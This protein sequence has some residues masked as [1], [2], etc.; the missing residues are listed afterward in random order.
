MPPRVVRSVVQGVGDGRGRCLDDLRDERCVDRVDRIRALW[1]VVTRV[2]EVGRV[3]EHHRRDV[4][5]P[6]RGVIRSP[7]IPR[8]EGVPQPIRDLEPHDPQVSPGAMRGE[9]LGGA[10]GALVVDRHQEINVIGSRTTTSAA[11]EISAASSNPSRSRMRR[12]WAGLSA[13]PQQAR[14]SKGDTGAASSGWRL[15]C[16]SALRT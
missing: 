13:Y 7:Q 1:A 9:R 3:S 2:P 11:C 14:C 4:A 12:P 16:V 15:T 10:A 6:E 5:P 8:G